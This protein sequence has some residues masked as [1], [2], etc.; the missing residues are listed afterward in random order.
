M[1]RPICKGT[2]TTHTTHTL[3]IRHTRFRCIIPTRWTDAHDEMQ[4]PLPFPNVRWPGTGRDFTTRRRSQTTDHG[5]RCRSDQIRSDQ[6]NKKKAHLIVSFFLTRHRQRVC[7]A[8]SYVARPPV[9]SFHH[10][11]VDSHHRSAAS[12]GPGNS[13]VGIRVSRLLVDL[14]WWIPCPVLRASGIESTFRPPAAP[15]LQAT[16]IHPYVQ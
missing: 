4:R 13:A 6:I 14:E 2:R 8:A 10:A 11:T 12:S 9:A 16:P 3:G 5:P 7:A 1:T 15:S